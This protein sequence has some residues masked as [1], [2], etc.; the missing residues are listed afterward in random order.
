MRN[1]IKHSIIIGSLALAATGC[2]KILD[3]DIQGSYT[4][5]NYFTSDQNAQLAVNAAYRP[6][7]FN[8]GANNAIWVLGDVASDDAIKGG[9][10]GDQADFDAVDKFN[11]LPTNSAVEAVWKNY[12]NG[13]YLCNVVLDGVSAGNTAISEATRKSAVAQ[14]KFLRAY[15]YFILT[16]AYGKIPL[17]LKVE[18]AVE[19]QTPARSQDSIYTQIEKDIQESLPNLPLP[20]QAEFGRVTQGA[21]LALL[22]KTYL[23]HNNLANHYQL[24]AQTADKVVALGYQLTPKYYDNFSTA[25]KQN[26]EAI[27]SVNHI[28]G[29]LGLGN[30]LNAW[31][32][33]AH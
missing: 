12:Y 9:N 29:T 14:A 15:Y 23:F 10:E 22:A 13:V 33:P 26:T 11:I 6:L 17:H 8:S 20:G 1:T 28:A 30:E 31:F 16:N 5:G 24:A 32:A 25:A 7:T 3:Q 4:P 18:T 2:S 19:A 21:A 27:L